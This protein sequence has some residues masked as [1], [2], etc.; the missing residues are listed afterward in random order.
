MSIAVTSVRLV[1]A[2]SYHPT[3]ICWFAINYS[4][5]VKDAGASNIQICEGTIDEMTFIGLFI[6]VFYKDEIRFIRHVF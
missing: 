1:L 3:V 5:S 4:V 6:V 2:G